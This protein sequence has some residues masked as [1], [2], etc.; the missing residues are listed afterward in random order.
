MDPSSIASAMEAYTA[1]ACPPDCVT[2]KEPRLSILI[3]TRKH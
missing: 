2:P 1:V 3:T